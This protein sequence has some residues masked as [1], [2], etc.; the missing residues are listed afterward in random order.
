MVT[1][2]IREFRFSLVA[3]PGEA[4]YVEID[5]RNFSALGDRRTER[6]YA[7][8]KIHFVYDEGSRT[9]SFDRANEPKLIF[10]LEQ[11]KSPV[12]GTDEALYDL[13]TSYFG[14]ASVS[15][16]PTEVVITGPNPLPVIGTA[17]GATLVVSG[18]VSTD[19]QLTEWR[20]PVINFPL[21]VFSGE[22]WLSYIR[23]IGDG[24]AWGVVKLNDT[25]AAPDIT[26]EPSVLELPV[27]NNNVAE[28]NYGDKPRHF[29]NG[30]WAYQVRR[31]TPFDNSVPSTAAIVE[32]GLLTSLS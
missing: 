17:P 9:F 21:E 12:L 23:V 25:N 20:S 18:V 6:L 19:K 22:C 5:I 26:N 13:L 16:T 11:V 4:P 31:L 7:S 10:T 32:I 28:I 30:I 29:L 24:G 27:Q 8:E 1:D 3:P 14:Q 15:A 2:K